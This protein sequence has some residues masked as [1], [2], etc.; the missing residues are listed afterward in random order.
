VGGV[1]LFWLIISP[2]MSVG[3]DSA[4]DVSVGDGVD[5]GGG[6]WRFAVD[7]VLYHVIP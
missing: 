3:M 5:G 2:M 7:Q 4:P 1:T 6:A